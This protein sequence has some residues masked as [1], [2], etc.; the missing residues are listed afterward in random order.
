MT[1]KDENIARPRGDFFFFFPRHAS[2]ISLKDD[3]WSTGSCPEDS[4][5]VP[6]CDAHASVVTLW[7]SSAPSRYI[8]QDVEKLTRTLLHI[9][10]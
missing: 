2:K 6:C 10:H 8:R 3:D 5:P 1:N 9:G 7:S 4:P